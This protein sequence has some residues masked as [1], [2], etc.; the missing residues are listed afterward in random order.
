MG[1][2]FWFTSLVVAV[3][4]VGLPCLGTWSRR[5]RLP[6]CA[7]DGVA[8]EPIYAVEIAAAEGQSRR[9]CCIRC[10]EYWLARNPSPSTVVQVTD[11]VT[12]QPIASQEAFFV[13]SSVLTNAVTG[14]R[15]HAFADRADAEAHANQFRGK[16]LTGDERPFEAPTVDGRQ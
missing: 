13:R 9:F 8:V 14:N 16:L 1:R 5:Q 10:A 4:A 2:Q 15:I 12:S 11:E 6:Q 3:L 7:V